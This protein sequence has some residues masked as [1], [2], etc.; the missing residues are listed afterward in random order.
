VKSNC[1]VGV[2][3]MF[4]RNKECCRRE[5][6]S[7]L[8][9]GGFRRRVNLEVVVPEGAEAILPCIEE[10]QLRLERDG[11]ENGHDLPRSRKEYSPYCP[12]KP[13]QIR[14]WRNPE[15]QYS[16]PKIRE[17]GGSKDFQVPTKH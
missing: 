11:E 3:L 12:K 1:A 2:T 10:H 17:C 7:V 6:G 15:A 5:V 16:S 14:S 8:W 4:I 9:I 13:K